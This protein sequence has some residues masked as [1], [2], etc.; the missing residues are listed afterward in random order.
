M[1][2]FQ[3]ILELGLEVLPHVAYRPEVDILDPMES[4]QKVV[5][6]DGTWS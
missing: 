1:K 3:K 6:V 2:T 4:W 5:D